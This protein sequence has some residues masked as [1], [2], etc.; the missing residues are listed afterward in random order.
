MNKNKFEFGYTIPKEP[1]FE[2]AMH[3][4]TH[5]TPLDG[6]TRRL[7]FF[8]TSDSIEWVQTTLNLTAIAAALN[9]STTDIE[10]TYLVNNSA[11]FDLIML[12]MCDVVIMTTGTYG[13]WGAWLSNA[14]KIIYYHNWPRPNSTL[15]RKFSREDF[16]PPSWI[17][18]QGPYYTF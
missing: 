14:M 16:Y 1:F 4:V 18:S 10:V 9:S 6:G 17:S 8:V 12:T 13:W 2:R 11:G 15:A 5:D 7:Q 3:N